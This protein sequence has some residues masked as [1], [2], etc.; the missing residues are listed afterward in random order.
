VSLKTKRLIWTIFF[1]GT[2]LVAIVSE[3]IAGVFHPAGAIPWTEYVAK[4][5]PWPVQLVAYVVLMVWLPIH[6]LRADQRLKAAYRN[7]Q[8]DARIALKMK[9]AQALRDAHERGY[10]AAL[11]DHAAP[12]QPPQR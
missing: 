7:G 12:A 6:F 4:Y 10:E 9:H 3:V 1:L 5:V 8:F 2:T 11:K